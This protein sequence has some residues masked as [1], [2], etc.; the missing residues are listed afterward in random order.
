MWGSHLLA[1]RETTEAAL[2]FSLALPGWHNLLC[3][4]ASTGTR[5]GLLCRYTTEEQGE[6]EEDRN[7]RRV[8]ISDLR[9][10][11]IIS[12]FDLTPD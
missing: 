2:H 8:I 6:E 5:T 3:F 12:R 10:I 11:F 7:M 9:N 4:A 1:Q